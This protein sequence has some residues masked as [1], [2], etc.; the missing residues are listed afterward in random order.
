MPLPNDTPKGINLIADLIGEKKANKIWGQIV[1][2][3]LLN[4]LEKEIL[5]NRVMEKFLDSRETVG[6]TKWEAVNDAMKIV[7]KAIHE[8]DQPVITR[9]ATAD[10][11]EC[12]GDTCTKCRVCTRNITGGII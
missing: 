9:L 5:F 7:Q 10:D 2:E 3:K 6:K 8:L 4:T 12:G 11:D 1:A